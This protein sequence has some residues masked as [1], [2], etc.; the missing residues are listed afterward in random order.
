MPIIMFFGLDGSG[1][2]TL[3]TALVEELSKQGFKTR[4]SWMRGTHTLAS[5]LAKFLARFNAFAGSDNPYYRISIPNKMRGLW[6]FIEFISVIP[7]IA[8]RLVVPSFLGYLV[9]AERSPADFVAW[10]SL[11][12][13]D[14]NYINRREAKFLLLLNA[15]VK[16]YVTCGVEE[17]L[18]RRN[19]DPNVL[20]R[21]I[22]LY[23][24]LSSIV[25]A[26]ILDTTDKSVEESFG[27][28]KALTFGALNLKNTF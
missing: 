20:K 17:L 28:L 1:K 6:R 24:R 4:V 8:L 16:I 7:V 22:D 25:K 2:T 19:G 12:T 11:V 15:S 9:V 23:N 3:A 21:Q 5:I 26:F 13:R 18:R 27:E 14:P 10:V